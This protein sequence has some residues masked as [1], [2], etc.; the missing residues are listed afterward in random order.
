VVKQ[1]RYGPE[2]VQGVVTYKTL[3]SVDNADL[4]LR[5]GMT[6]TANIT[7][8]QTTNVLLVPNLALRFL[9]P[10]PEETARTRGTLI[11]RLF[12]RPPPASRPR[13]TIDIKSKPQHVWVLRDGQLLAVSVNTG[14][15]DGIMTEIT[16]GEITV[17]T[18]VVTDVIGT[19][20]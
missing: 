19:S 2:T 16:S 17:G 15:T 3:L 6:A 18:E 20:P 4:A 7:V 1:V 13:D 10:V 8:R 14:S 12:P 11:S 5:P 9:P